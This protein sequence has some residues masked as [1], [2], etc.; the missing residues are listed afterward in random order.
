MVMMHTKQMAH[1]VGKNPHRSGNVPV[2]VLGHSNVILG[3]GATDT[4]VSN[5][6]RGDLF[7]VDRDDVPGLQTHCPVIAIVDQVA[8]VGFCCVVSWVVVLADDSR[9]D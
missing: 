7:V 5:A 6:T 4:N 3:G 8:A 9:S 1:L 2:L